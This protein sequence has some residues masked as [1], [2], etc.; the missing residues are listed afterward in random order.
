MGSPEDAMFEPRDSFVASDARSRQADTV[1]SADKWPAGLE[2]QRPRIQQNPIGTLLGVGAG[3]GALL[4]AA[5]SQHDR[6]L[7]GNAAIGAAAGA[8][9]GAIGGSGITITR[10]L[11]LDQ[12]LR[13]ALSRL[14]VTFV[15]LRQYGHYEARLVFE[16]PSDGFRVAKA[17]ADPSRPWAEDELD[18]WLYVTLVVDVLK[19]LEA[20]S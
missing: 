9:A 19:K 8:L 2:R 3:V 6:D 1:T 5:F 10:A 16:T 14:G 13:L 4:G 20:N 11:S 15:S 18:D 7:A 17:N 12:S